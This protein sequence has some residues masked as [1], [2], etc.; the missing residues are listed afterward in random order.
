MS[1]SGGIARTL[2]GIAS[3]QD[4]GERCQDDKS[5]TYWTYYQNGDPVAASWR[6]KCLLLKNVQEKRVV[7]NVVSG[8]KMCGKGTTITM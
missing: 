1:Y 8:D 2:L 6:K 7:N 3:W 5:C 4:C